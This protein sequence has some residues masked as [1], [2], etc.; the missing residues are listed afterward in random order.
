MHEIIIIIFGLVIGSFLNAFIYR[1]NIKKSVFK[2]QSFCPHCRH[3]LAPYD[4]IPVLSFIFLRGSCRY[5]HKKISW[6]Y[7][8]VELATALSFLAFYC[9]FGLNGQALFHALITCFLIVILVGIFATLLLLLRLLRLDALDN[10]DN[11]DFDFNFRSMDLLVRSAF[12]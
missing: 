2:G 10:L 5:C 1:L 11:L 12:F 9:Q 3:Q 8:L 7:P 6:Q 4:L